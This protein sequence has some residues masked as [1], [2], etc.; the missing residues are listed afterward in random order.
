MERSRN[1]AKVS[2]TPRSLT[3]RRIPS[4]AVIHLRLSVVTTASAA[5]RILGTRDGRNYRERTPASENREIKSLHNHSVLDRLLSSAYLRHQV[6]IPHSAH[7]R[8]RARTDV[9]AVKNQPM[10][11]RRQQV[12][13]DLSFSKARSARVFSTGCESDAVR[14]PEYVGNRDGH[15]LLLP[16]RRHWPSCVPRRARRCRLLDQLGTSPPNSS[17]SMRAMPARFFAL[18]LGW[19]MLLM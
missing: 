14:D 8:A 17:Q 7:L 19:E 12:R 16:D 13:R 2:R 18:L 1:R 15:H 10:V 4:V 5:G 3:L 9:A 6:E 11:G